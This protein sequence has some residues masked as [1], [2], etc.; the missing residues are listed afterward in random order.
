MQKILIA[1]ISLAACALLLLVFLSQQ[2]IIHK[3]DEI[4]PPQTLPQETLPPLETTLPPE[5]V[6]TT[7]SETAEATSPETAA[8]PETT[9]DVAEPPVTTVSEAFAEVTTALETE[10]VTTAET[11]ESQ[12]YAETVPEPVTA[13]SEISLPISETEPPYVSET[14]DSTEMSAES[15]MHEPHEIIRTADQSGWRYAIRSFEL[16]DELPQGISLSD[17]TQAFGSF[18]TYDESG[19]AISRGDS[20]ASH[21]SDSGKYDGYLGKEYVWAVLNFDLTN[22]TGKDDYIIVGD[23]HLSFGK[24]KKVIYMGKER[25]RYEHSVEIGYMNMHDV[26]P[27]IPKDMQYFTLHF[28]ADETKQLVFCYLIEKKYSDEEFYLEMNIHND[29]ESY[30]F[31]SLSEA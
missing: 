3:P 9:T 27:D 19:L 6:T 11:A 10:A 16:L 2:G 24:F 26:M 8:V 1:I 7:I 21:L 12:T 14:S 22:L 18:D 17:T 25:Y 5:T 4:L 15:E 31:L 30:G 20:V 13:E 29:G 28:D 23:L